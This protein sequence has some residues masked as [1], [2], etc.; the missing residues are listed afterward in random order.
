M[1]TPELLKLCAEKS[2][3]AAG[4]A[5][6]VLLND[7]GYSNEGLN[8]KAKQDGSLVSDADIA[9]QQVISRIL[10]PLGI[11]MICEEAAMTPYEERRSWKYFWLIDPLDGTESYLSNRSGFAVNIALCDADGPII[12]VVADPLGNIIYQGVLGSG[13]KVCQL[14]GSCSVFV[15]PRSVRKPYH[16]LTSWAERAALEE[17]VPP[18]IDI[19]DVVSRPAS[20]ALKFCKL[21]MGEAEIHARTG[22]YMEWDCAAGDG[23]LRAMGVNV[24]DRNTGDRINYNSED[25]WVR[26][27][28]ASRV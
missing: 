8:V 10:A 27:L 19:A 9:S 5:S 21:A 26:G 12:G 6:R 17:L 20:G 14:D 13:V 3:E 24:I 28:Y 1:L 2:V 23:I 7:L 15:E 4:A 25:L 18:G 16:L 11:P 22:P